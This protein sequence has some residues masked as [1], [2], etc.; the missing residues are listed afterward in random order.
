[1]SEAPLASRLVGKTVGRWKVVEKI[2]KV[3][4]D[5]SGFWS[6]CYKA[7]DDQ[8]RLAFLKSFNYHYAFGQNASSVDVL[9]F[10]TENFTYE[11]DLLN[12][13]ADTKC[14]GS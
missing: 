12:F 9:K 14:A 8:G 7:H 5:D 13:C 2:K 6:T 3:D 11:R 10:M 4:A 1:M